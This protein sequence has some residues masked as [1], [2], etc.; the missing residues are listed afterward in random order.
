MDA[1]MF[2]MSSTRNKMPPKTHNSITLGA[3]MGGEDA[4]AATNEHILAFRRLIDQSCRGFYSNTIREFGIVLRIDGSL[5]RWNKMGVENAAIRQRGSHATADIFVPSEVWSCGNPKAFRQFLALE[6]EKTIYE[7]GKIAKRR[8][9]EFS[10][11]GL[12]HDVNSAV[13]DY[14]KEL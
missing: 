5:D 10:L 12:I 14:L 9:I 6:F 11:E 1:I 7:I 8:E 13:E 4:A 3:Q 2:G